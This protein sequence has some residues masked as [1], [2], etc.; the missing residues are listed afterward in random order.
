MQKIKAACTLFFALVMA[1]CTAGAAQAA[2]V[3]YDE[4]VDGDLAITSP[5]FTFTLD[6][7]GTHTVRGNS[8]TI[9][10]VGCQGLNEMFDCDSFG[11]IVPA[12]LQLASV[13]LSSPI[14]GMQ[15]LVNTGL[16]DASGDFMGAL[17]VDGSQTSNLLQLGAGSYNISW[18]TL[19]V[20]DNGSPYLF[21]FDVRQDVPEPASLALAGLGLLGLALSRRRPGRVART[22]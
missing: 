19:F 4:S 20:G 17:L 15:W 7:P 18:D 5:L 11:F 2:L 14:T 8:G 21:S 12:G 16:E 22:A 1:L 3:H 10:P 6:T 13:S 9:V